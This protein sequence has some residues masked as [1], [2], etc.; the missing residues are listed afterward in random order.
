MVAPD[1]AFPTTATI[2][3]ED[4]FESSALTLVSPGSG[5]SAL[6]LGERGLLIL[7]GNAA[8]WAGLRFEF[9]DGETLAMS[10]VPQHSASFADLVVPGGHPPGFPA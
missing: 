8:D 10:D 3:L 9:S 7:A 6:V 2:V 4:G 5:I 1:G